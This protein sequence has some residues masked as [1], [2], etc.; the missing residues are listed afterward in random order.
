M[1]IFPS[2]ECKL[3]HIPSLPDALVTSCAC[4]SRENS[5]NNL[6]TFGLLDFKSVEVK[7]GVSNSVPGGL[8]P[9][10]V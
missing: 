8:Q 10:R 3:F 4:E 6:G 2:T 7:A 5:E 9:C 1:A